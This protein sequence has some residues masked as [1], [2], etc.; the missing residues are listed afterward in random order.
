M[1]DWMTSRQRSRNMAAIRSKHT[2]PELLV[3][4]LVFSMG[5]R[6]RLHVAK[7]PGK[8]DLVF[9][10]SRKIIEVRGCFWHRH[11]CRDGKRVPGSNQDY[12]IAKIKRNRERDAA[13]QKQ[14][15]KDGW[16]ILVIWEC[17]TKDVNQLRI[18]L[19]QFLR[20]RPSQGGSNGTRFKF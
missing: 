15:V 14:L 18:Q 7:L 9:R 4:K 12:W 8:P 20:Q 3:R 6:Y 16:T 5:Y 19:R 13:N 10:R 11:T 17:E 2:K 1:A